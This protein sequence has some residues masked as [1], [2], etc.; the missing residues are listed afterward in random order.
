MGGGGWG[1]LIDAMVETLPCGLGGLGAAKSC[2][3][4]FRE[5]SPAADLSNSPDLSEMSWS[6]P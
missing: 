5:G 1:A 4:G 6:K 3:L 2:R